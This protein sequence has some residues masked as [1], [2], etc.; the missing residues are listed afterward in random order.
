MVWTQA[1][2]QIKRWCHGQKTKESKF[3]IQIIQL[4]Y[5]TFPR[6]AL[7]KWTECVVK[8]K[9]L[10]WN[11]QAARNLM[12]LETHYPRLLV[13]VPSQLQGSGALTSS[14]ACGRPRCTMMIF[15]WSWSFFLIQFWSAPL[16]SSKCPCTPQAHS[17]SL[18]FYVFLSF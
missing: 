1:A 5:K 14:G 12:K 17:C 16:W 2:L 10:C 13:Q 3:T 15:F 6:L 4:L 11:S 9:V 8:L 18:T 7:G